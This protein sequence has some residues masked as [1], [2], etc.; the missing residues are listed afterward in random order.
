MFPKARVFL[1]QQPTTAQ[2]RCSSSY[3]NKWKEIFL[4]QKF[5]AV[6]QGNNF[7]DPFSGTKKPQSLRKP[8]IASTAPLNHFPR[9]THP[10]SSFQRRGWRQMSHERTWLPPLKNIG[11]WHWTLEHAESIPINC[12][13]PPQAPYVESLRDSKPQH[14]INRKTTSEGLKQYERDNTTYRDVSRHHSP[15]QPAGMMNL[16]AAKDW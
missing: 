3:F 14:C 2:R 9:R 11:P 5:A 12:M 16:R 13:L 6:W 1:Q 7:S 8:I 4:Q 15:L 10:D